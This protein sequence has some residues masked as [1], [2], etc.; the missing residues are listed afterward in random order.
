MQWLEQLEQLSRAQQPKDLQIQLFPNWTGNADELFHWMQSN[1]KWDSP[2]TRWGVPTPRQVAWFGSVRY[3]YSGVCH[4]PT[5]EW[6]PLLNELRRQLEEHL[7]ARF[8]SVLANRY[9]DGSDT[10]AWHSDN[11]PELGPNPTIASISLGAT[12][13]FKLRSHQKEEVHYDLNHGDLLVMS[14]ETQTHWQH[15]IPRTKGPVGPRVN[16]TFRWT[17]PQPRR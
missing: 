2:M 11:E 9:R 15:C 7:N 3:M 12:R 16:L 4:E 13:R 14:G 1:I 10:V 5:P 6:P 17:N 8:N